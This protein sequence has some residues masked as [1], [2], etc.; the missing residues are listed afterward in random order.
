MALYCSK[1]K[2]SALLR[3]IS[4]KYDVDFYCLN[5]L[6]QFRTKNKLK[7][8]KKVQEN[9]DLFEVVIPSEGTKILEF[10][11]YQKS[12]KL[13]FIIL[14]D[15]ESLIEKLNRWKNT[16]AKSSTIEIG[17]HIHQVFQCLQYLYLKK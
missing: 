10:N 3:G 13:P 2:L 4:S 15:L 12:D 1:K 9:K 11:Q 8:H 6:H 17:E 14:S 16:P 5:C 7:P